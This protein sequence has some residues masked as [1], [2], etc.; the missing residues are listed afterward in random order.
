MSSLREQSA[1]EVSE[2]NKLA[3]SRDF[4]R[5]P[6]E[7]CLATFWRQASPGVAY[8]RCELPA[9]YLPGQMVEFDI[10]Y[11]Q[12]DNARDELSLPTSRGTAI[13][14]YMGDDMRARVA[15]AWQD[16]GHRTLMEMDDNYTESPGKWGVAWTKTVEESRT[17]IG[18]SHEQH[19]H[20]AT[21]VDGLVVSTPYLGDLYSEYN[22]NIFVCR[23]SIEPADYPEP[24]K[25]DDGIFRI[26]FAGSA[27]HIFDYP[28]VK[29]ALKWAMRQKD[30]E[31]TLMGFSRPPAFD[32]EVISWVDSIEDYR[33]SLGRFDLGLAP[34]V[35]NRWNKGKSD[36]KA[37]EYAMM[38]AMPLP[39][40]VEAY[41]PWTDMGW[42]SAQTEEDWIELVQYAVRNRDWVREQAAVAKEYVLNERVIWKEIPRWREA[43][44]G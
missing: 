19:K 8:W 25:P 20:L 5:A 29:K 39:S 38:G 27:I 1:A 26:V 31:V 33:A 3:R 41:R 24:D 36:I 34:L 42:P 10:P 4:L 11:V 35:G 13:W 44:H 21:L 12:W 22:D 7:D 40:A 9:R 6:E 16:L 18:Y 32:G 43:V 28:M 37:M 14:Q 15:L 2:L 30:V 17:M 23:N